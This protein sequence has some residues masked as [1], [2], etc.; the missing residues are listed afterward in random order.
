M[1]EWRLEIPAPTKWLSA[2]SRT[3]RRAQTADR[4]TWRSAAFV[5]ARKRKLPT[6]LARVHITATCAFP[7][8]RRRD[9]ANWYPTIKAA[10]DGLVDYGLIADDDDAHLIG[11]DMRASDRRA[12]TPL[13]LLVLDIREVP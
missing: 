1:S 12:V 2:N 3:D 5:W 4:R 10:V 13:G 8:Q 11:P 9:V 7:N 6:G